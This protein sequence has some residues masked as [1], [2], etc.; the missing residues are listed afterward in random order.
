MI[1]DY[2]YIHLDK[3]AHILDIP[4]QYKIIQNKINA[5]N[6]ETDYCLSVLR[7]KNI[8]LQSSLKRSLINVIYFN[9]KLVIVL[10]KQLALIKVDEL[11][12]N[13]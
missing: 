13:V 11:I 9:N 7:Q 8:Y 1:N 2:D 10:E 3:H 5:L 4:N 6:K 12:D